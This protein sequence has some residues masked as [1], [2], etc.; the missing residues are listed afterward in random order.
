MTT[1]SQVTKSDMSPELSIASRPRAESW[2]AFR[3]ILLVTLVG[4]LTFVGLAVGLELGARVALPWREFNRCLNGTGSSPAYCVSGAVKLW[5][6]PSF[7]Y[8]YN[9]CGYRSAHP[10]STA[11]PNAK[12]VAVL[13][14]SFGYGFYVPYA[15]TFPARAGDALSRACG[16]PVDFQNLSLASGSI[17]GQPRWQH[18]RDRVPG[19][20][21]LHP[22][23]V[24]VVLSPGDLAYFKKPLAAYGSTEPTPPPVKTGSGPQWAALLDKINRTILTRSEAIAIVRDIAFHDDGVFL[25]NFKNSPAAG[26]LSPTFDSQWRLRL[27][28]A[29]TVLGEME[30]QVRATGTPFI[31]VYIPDYAEAVLARKPS[32]DPTLSAYALPNALGSIVERHGGSFVD[33]TADIAKR[34]RLYREYY[35]SIDHPNGRGNAIIAQGVVSALEKQVPAFA[36][37]RATAG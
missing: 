27:Q 4:V 35:L 17:G 23:A 8:S 37:C 9:D 12:R 18:I 2:R 13:G 36:A 24:L 7:T 32:L 10:C 16:V 30:N 33:L 28:I 14:T 20:L 15:D 25:N 31:A 26:F 29:D 3:R 22:K 5:E 1:D 6:G 21:A 11:A 19:A 34:P